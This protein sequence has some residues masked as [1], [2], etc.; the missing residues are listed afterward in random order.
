MDSVSA[1]K[2]RQYSDLV[3][4]CLAAM[5]ESV[6]LAHDYLRVPADAYA[7]R[8]VDALYGVEIASDAINAAFELSYSDAFAAV[9]HEPVQ[10]EG[11][12]ESSMHDAIRSVAASVGYVASAVVKDW[13]PGFYTPGVEY[14]V[15][16]LCARDDML[17]HLEAAAT[18]ALDCFPSLEELNRAAA[19]RKQELAKAMSLDCVC[20][21]L[22]EVKLRGSKAGRPEEWLHLEVWFDNKR[23]AD[24]E[25]LSNRV[26]L[27]E[28]YNNDA[29]LR[30]WRKIEKREEFRNALAN[31]KKKKRSN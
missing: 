5:M 28:E 30:K 18:S 31:W 12:P 22:P 14:P 13:D 29:A 19:I 10:L 1:Q 21:D 3:A 9:C 16:R 7:G 6:Q 27:I 8:L 4:E 24:L 2:L 25:D 15:P 26:A 23:L 20:H 11:W 17:A